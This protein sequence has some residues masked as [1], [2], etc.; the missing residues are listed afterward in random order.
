MIWR[1]EEKN[2][3]ENKKRKIK[4]ARWFDGVGGV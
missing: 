4:G 3:H 2:N 1:K